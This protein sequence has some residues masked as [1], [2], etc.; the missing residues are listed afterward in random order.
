MEGDELQLHRCLQ[1]FP[2]LP[3]WIIEHVWAHRLME[4][5]TVADLSSWPEMDSQ[6]LSLE[7]SWRLRVA[8]ARVY[9][10]VKNRDMERFEA[11][12]VFL[13]NTYRLLPRLVAPIKHMKIMFGLKT[14][15]IM[16]M[17]KQGRGM[18]D[19]VFKI[20][21]FFPSKLPQ[22]QDHCNQHEMFLMRKNHLDFKALAQRLAMDKDK[23]QDYITNHME[24]Q[25]GEH[26]AQKV[27][28]RLLQYLYK[29]ETVLP[30]DTC[31]DEILKKGSP[32]TEEEK[33]LL[34]V[35]TKDPMTVMMTLKK[36]L[37]CDV[38][39]CSLGRV[40]QSSS[41]SVVHSSSS[42]ALFKSTEAPREL[43]PTV[44]RR[45]EEADRD[46]LLESDSDVR[47]PQQMEED[48]REKEE[49]SRRSSE[50]VDEVTSS[51]Q[52]CSK[53]QRWVKTILQECPDECSEELL[54][55]ATVSSSPLL[56]Q[57]SSSITSSSQDITPSD[58]IPSLS[59]QQNAPKGC[60]QQEDPEDK[61]SSGSSG[62]TSSTSQQEPLPQP[63][64]AQDTPLPAVLS[65]LVRLIDIRSIGG[66]YHQASPNNFTSKKPA[67]SA[68]TPQVS[69]HHR[70][71]TNNAILPAMLKDST[72]DQPET[73]VPT[74]PPN[75]THQLQTAP[76]DQGESASTSCQP[77]APKC[78][79]RL[80]RK[81]RRGCTSTRQSQALDGFPS[82]EQFKTAPTTFQTSCSP[83]PDDLNIFGPPTQDVSTSTVSSIWTTNLTTVKSSQQVVPQ[84]SISPQTDQPYSTIISFT[85]N[86]NCTAVRSETSRARRTRMRLSTPCQTLLLQSKLLQPCVSLTR[87][88]VQECF[89]MSNGRCSARYVEPDDNNDDGKENDEGDSSFDLNALYSS[90]S[91]SG[92][93]EDSL[94]CD[95]NYKPWFTKK[96]LLLEYE[97]ARSLINT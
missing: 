86:S 17:L 90:H 10:T 83:M 92:D 27:E 89:R 60:E 79:S 38:A 26:Y 45:Q 32:V 65:P 97:A 1:S 13:E 11:A 56:F 81:F 34:G 50:S 7:E 68:S 82:A 58:L 5:H 76:L 73:T 78:I 14:M 61:L 91:S 96:R 23:L 31:I 16:W 9:S 57:S 85:S 55:Q 18:I 71:S 40:P 6:P 74:N 37:H 39:S 8:S 12:L 24:E 20:N 25:Y 35:I 46:V 2:K 21:Q 22:Y 69:P 95:P 59:A 54:L 63:S 48:D 28:D 64:S 36:L 42:K 77:P 44:F 53:H 33:L 29:L 88:S 84:S 30:G 70:T 94:V 19:T 66:M 15:V 47:R 4:I 75:A 72:F 3:L 41:K 67:A 51:P 43:Q 87:L 80:S 49:V 62:L 52:F 93:S